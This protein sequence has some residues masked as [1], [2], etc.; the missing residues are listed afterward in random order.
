[1]TTSG[2]AHPD[3]N[4]QFDWLI[5]NFANQ[6]ADGIYDIVQWT[7]MGASKFAHDCISGSASRFWSAIIRLAPPSIIRLSIVSSVR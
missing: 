4:R 2:A 7:E 1:M 5:G 3:R 6:G